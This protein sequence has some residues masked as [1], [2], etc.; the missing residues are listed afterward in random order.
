MV[1]FG[2][3]AIVA[4]LVLG[5]MITGGWYLIDASKRLFTRGSRKTAMG[6]RMGQLMVQLKQEGFFEPSVEPVMIRNRAISE[7][8]SES[9]KEESFFWGISKRNIFIK[10]NPYE[11][12]Y[13][14]LLVYGNK[15]IGFNWRGQL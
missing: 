14:T 1:R 8:L 11:D 2:G 13:D 12:R 9:S 3:F 10:E 6:E 15:S 5:F 4:L 7:A